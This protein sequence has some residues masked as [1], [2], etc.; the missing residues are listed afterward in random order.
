MKRL[1]SLLGGL[2][3]L[4]SAVVVR[5]VNSYRGFMVKSTATAQTPALTLFGV[6]TAALG[7]RYRSRFAMLTGLLAATVG[8]YYVTRVTAPHDGLERAFGA[9]WQ[10]DIPPDIE[11]R[12]LQRRLSMRLPRVPAP[13][14]ERDVPF[15]SFWARVPGARQECR[16]GR[17]RTLPRRRE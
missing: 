4:S 2:A 11:R 9:G 1:A 10:H 16:A 6:V 5:P 17:T 15:L 3:A 7:V 12:M 14:W 8:T 13:R